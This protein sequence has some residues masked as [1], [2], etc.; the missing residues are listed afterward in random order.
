MADSG[1][2]VKLLLF[3]CQLSKN[4][5][6]T[7]PSLAAIFH[8]VTLLCCFHGTNHGVTLS[9]SHVLIAPMHPSL[10]PLC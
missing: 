4:S 1:F 5:G 7:N 8:P 10:T 6:P 9:Y 3:K 2:L